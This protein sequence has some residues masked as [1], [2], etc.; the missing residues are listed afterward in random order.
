MAVEEKGENDSDKKR[1]RDREIETTE[2]SKKNKW[3][4]AISAGGTSRVAPI[5]FSFFPRRRALWWHAFVCDFFLKK[6]E[7]RECAPSRFVRPWPFRAM[8]TSYDA[9]GLL[10]GGR[11]WSFFFPPRPQGDAPGRPAATKTIFYRRPLFLS[12][13]FSLFAPFC[14]VGSGDLAMRPPPAPHSCWE[15]K[16]TKRKE[17]PLRLLRA[18]A[19]RDQGRKRSEKEKNPV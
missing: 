11:S 3:R 10:Y 14:D 5:V 19:V 4:P 8:R 6:K 1:E 16:N 9:E 12:D 15:E 2:T 18:R 7:R 13:P 17:G